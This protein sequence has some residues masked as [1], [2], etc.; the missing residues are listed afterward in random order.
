MVTEVEFKMCA[1]ALQHWSKTFADQ[2]GCLSTM[3]S[4]SYI[5][6]KKKKMKT[7]NQINKNEKIKK[8]LP[9][10]CHKKL[11]SLQAFIQKKNKKNKIK[12]QKKNKK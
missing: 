11:Q 4:Y 8:N 10:G 3:F 7:I 12:T 2:L 6:K 5:Q 9:L 1:L